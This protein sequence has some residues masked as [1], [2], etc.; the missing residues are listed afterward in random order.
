M[1]SRKQNESIAGGYTTNKRLKKIK[2]SFDVIDPRDSSKVLKFSP[3]LE[4]LIMTSKFRDTDYWGRRRRRD[5][6]IKI[7]WCCLS[8]GYR[9]CVC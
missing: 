5:Q 3:H 8:C 4:E 7:A 1:L 9:L 2:T 6:S